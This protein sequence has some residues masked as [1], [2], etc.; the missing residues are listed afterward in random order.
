MV[1]EYV[2]RSG[3]SLLFEDL[4]SG[5]YY[6]TSYRKRTLPKSAKTIHVGM[7]FHKKKGNKL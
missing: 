6:K 4:V 3:V 5:I 7:H 2:H 1:D